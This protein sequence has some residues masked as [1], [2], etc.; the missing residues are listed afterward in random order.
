MIFYEVDYYLCATLMNLDES[1][2][3]H[4]RQTLVLPRESL[5]G[6]V[7]QYNNNNSMLVNRNE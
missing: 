5:S 3:K 1:A 4:T 2:Q 7:M 6:C